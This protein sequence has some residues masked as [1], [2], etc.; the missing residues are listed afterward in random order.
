VKISSACLSLGLVLSGLVAPAVR[1][2]VSKA[3]EAAQAAAAMERAQRQAVNPMRMILEAS[4]VRRKAA[5]AEPAEATDAAL[6]RVAARIGLPAAGVVAVVAPAAVG[7]LAAPLR[8]PAEAAAAAVPAPAPILATAPTPA[9]SIA[10]ADTT[11]T[12]T[13]SAPTPLADMQPLRPEPVLDLVRDSM[14]PTPQAVA[15]SAVPSDSVTA[16]IPPPVAPRAAATPTAKLLPPKLLTMVE[17]EIPARLMINLQQTV[18]V[19]VDLTLRADGTVAQVVFAP[20]VS[21]ALQ[22]SLQAAVEQWRYEPLSAA[23]AAADAA[24]RLH[25]VQLVINP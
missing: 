7:A 14:T 2:D 1:A 9:I 21:R 4:K 11:A 3:D 5:E 8:L 16:S 24:P 25:R 22:R 6:R 12:A 15:P 18:E 23:A 17:P 13:A 20:G 19:Q 10:I